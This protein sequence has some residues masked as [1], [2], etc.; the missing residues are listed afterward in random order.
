[1]ILTLA[2]APSVEPITLL[3]AKAHL[4]IDSTTFAGGNTELISIAPAAHV[5]AAA[6]SLEGT[7]VDVSGKKALV[8]LTAG[9]LGAGGTVDA[10]VQESSD[11]IAYADVASGSFT[12]VTTASDNAT[13]ELEYDGLQQ[14]IRA[15]STVAGATSDFG[16]S[17]LTK[18]PNTDEDDLITALI[19]SARE[20]IEN[21][22]R[23][24]LI[25]QT[26]DIYFQSWPGADEYG[27]SSFEIPKAPL[28]SVT[29]VYYTDTDGTE[30]TVS[31]DDYD[32]DTDSLP[33]RVTLAYGASWPSAS[34]H[35]KNP[36]RIRFVAGYGAAGSN[37]PQTIKQAMYYYI[38]QLF[39]FREPT[40][41][42]AVSSV[43]FGDDP[44]MDAMLSSYVV[45]TL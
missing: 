34:L 43:K 25:T 44:V 45:H 21:I 30:N 1:M 38:S 31:T 36:I 3:E 37:V 29:G 18:T 7:G 40:I 42:T 35:P 5:V 33:G 24:A 15:V 8:F 2:T 41:T 14:Y 23:R 16:V 39:E 19:V 20:Y 9:T 28:Q 6:Y 12:Q 27:V 4:R 10:K 13:F 11:D 22:T 17:I 32:V 26:W